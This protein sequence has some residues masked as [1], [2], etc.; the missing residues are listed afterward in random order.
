MTASIG[1]SF[2][3][4][5]FFPP[6][7]GNV[8][9]EPASGDNDPLCGA[10]AWEIFAVFAEQRIALSNWMRNS[11]DMFYSSPRIRTPRNTPKNKQPIK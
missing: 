8:D 5:A 2:I 11:G 9:S 3:F 1:N 10:Q 4:R 7:E 6:D